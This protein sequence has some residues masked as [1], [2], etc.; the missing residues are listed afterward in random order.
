MAQIKSSGYTAPKFMK[1]DGCAAFYTDVASVASAPSVNDT[2]DFTLPA[3][4]ELHLVRL[5]FTDMDTNGTPLI[6]FKVGFRKLNDGDTLT[7]DDDYFAAAG[8]TTARAG[9]LLD[10]VFT[11]IKFNVDVILSVTIT[12]AAA[13]FAAGTVTLVAAGNADGP[14]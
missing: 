6:A 1:G 4:L 5:V 3:G 8:Q 7:A 10:C 11:P 13:T 14:K 2:I 9:G 12:A